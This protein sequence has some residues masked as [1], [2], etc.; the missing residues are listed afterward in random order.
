MQ[1]VEQEN[2]LKYLGAWNMN[3]GRCNTDRRTRIGMAKEVFS[4]RKELLTKGL[5]CP[6]KKT[7]VRALIVSV[8][9]YCVKSRSLKMIYE[10]WKLFK[11]GYGDKWRR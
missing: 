6:A 5:S 10:H 9:L 3:D 11:C 2:N 7:I 4:K 8:A 1:A